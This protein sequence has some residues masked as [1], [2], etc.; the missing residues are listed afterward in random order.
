VVHNDTVNFSSG[1]GSPVLCAEES[2]G[3][4]S[5]DAPLV[6]GP[7]R[8]LGVA[9]DPGGAAT[10]MSGRFFVEGK[11]DYDAP[12]PAFID[13]YFSPTGWMGDAIEG[14]LT[15]DACN[16]PV[17]YCS[18]ACNVF[19]YEGKSQ[20]WAGVIW[21]APDGNWDGS[22]PGVRF[23]PG[24]AA[25]EF[26]AWGDA[27]GEVISF[28]AGNIDAGETHAVS[29]DFTLGTEPATYRLELIPGKAED[30]TAA[31]G[32][33]AGAPSAGTSMTFS[34]TDVRWVTK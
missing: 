17:D 3:T 8:V 28:F 33:A 4:L 6:P 14:G 15:M 11:A 23:S 22:Q 24:A 20:G 27:G 26:T 1:A 10:T 31:F 16:Q 13:N 25:V 29:Q 34:V 5:F 12:L 9:R 19:T 2:T 21:H 30:I 7:Y 18:I 32:W